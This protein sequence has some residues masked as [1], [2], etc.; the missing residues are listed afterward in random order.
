LRLEKEFIT[1]LH[2]E[3][4]ELFDMHV[5]TDPDLKDA[6]RK[7]IVGYF[8]DEYYLEAPFDYA[9]FK[10]I[11][12][13]GQIDDNNVTFRTIVKKDF[14]NT[15]AEIDNVAL[16]SYDDKWFIYKEEG[17]TKVPSLWS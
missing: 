11:S 15:I 13:E 6:I 14:G 12:E 1:A 7:K 10:R 3:E 17:E 9:D 8:L 5:Y 2:H 4:N 16:S